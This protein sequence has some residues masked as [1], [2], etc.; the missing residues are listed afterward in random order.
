MDKTW[1]NLLFDQ[2][3]DQRT[4]PQALET[5]RKIP[6]KNEITEGN[7]DELKTDGERLVPFLL[8]ALEDKRGH[9]RASMLLGLI[10]SPTCIQP[11]KSLLMNG[12]SESNSDVQRWAAMTLL[13]VGDI[14]FPAIETL[15]ESTPEE[16]GRILLGRM[17]HFWD[18][19]NA[20]TRE[21]IEI[22]VQL[23]LKSLSHS[24]S[25]ESSTIQKDAAAALLARG[26]NED[27]AVERLRPLLDG[28]D[29]EVRL[30]VAGMLAGGGVETER[31]IDLGIAGLSADDPRLRVL[32]AQVLGRI[33]EPASR[34]VPDLLDH[35]DEQ[36]RYASRAIKKSLVQIGPVGIPEIVKV[37]N[38][39][40]NPQVRARCAAVLSGKGAEAAFD[41]L[42][43]LAIHD[44]DDNV[45]WRA[46]RALHMIKERENPAYL[47]AILVNS[48]HRENG[49][50]RWRGGKIAQ[51]GAYVFPLW[52]CLVSNDEDVRR[53]TFE[54]VKKF[55]LHQQEPLARWW[56]RGVMDSELEWLVNDD[57][58]MIRR[59]LEALTLLDQ[60][61][62]HHESFLR[63]SAEHTDDS[64]NELARRLLSRLD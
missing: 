62:I 31:A 57:P 34:A 43:R 37:M 9:N 17:S 12:D 45:R 32:A 51:S 30:Q 52:K 18:Q 39:D 3:S 64:I 55:K 21:L 1:L 22:A 56:V 44:P 16:P 15:L 59:R 58:Q 54:L 2:A 28:D 46:S 27:S 60:H 61:L 36:D 33:G 20:R 7:Q 24:G 25:E 41:D 4:W 13:R 35:L 5:V 40:S 63:Q 11:L 8:K 47:E 48:N 23:F 42:H 19:E 50:Y 49:S 29:P 14:A 26:V 38:H 6:W 10:A 53:T